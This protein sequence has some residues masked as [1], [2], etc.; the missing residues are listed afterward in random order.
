MLQNFLAELK[1]RKVLRVAGAYAVVAWGALQIADKL[2]PALL[3]PQW[4]ITFVAMLLLIGLP[5]TAII[6]WAFEMTPEGLR[7]TS[8]EIGPDETPARGTWIEAALLLSIVAVAGITVVQMLHRAEPATAPGDAVET[9][10]PADSNS[11][12][13][14]PFTSFSDD[15]DSNYFADGLTEELI[16]DLAHIAGL[17]VSGRTSSFYFKNRNEDLRDIGRK[18]GVAQVLEGS[19]RR[20]GEKLR[21]TVQ[22]ISTADG[23][24]L[25]SQTYDRELNDIFEIQDDVAEHVASVLEMTLGP[26]RPNAPGDAED[27]RQYLIASALLHER[28]LEPLTQARDLFARLKDREPDNVDALAGYTQATMLLAGAFMTLDFEPAARDAI[29]TIE[30]ALTIDPDSVTA[31]VA[32]GAAYT[33][34]LHRT[35]ESRYR[36]LAQRSLARAVELAPDDPEAL[37]SY[38]SLLNEIGQFD[39]AYAAL[40]RAVARDPMSRLAQAQLITALEGLGRLA[41]ARERLLILA[42]MY[43]DYVFAQSELGELLL[44]QGQIDAALPYLRKAHASKTSPRAS[45]ALAH[46]YVNLGLD[47][48][49]RQ[50][51]AELSYSPRSQ[52]FGEVILLNVRGDDAATFRLAQSQLELT[53]DPIW[54][55]LLINA[56]LTLG[57]LATARRELAHTDPLLLTSLDATH[58]QPESALYAG[59]LLKREGHIEDA[60]RLLDSL[61]AAQAPPPHGYDPVARKL[62]RAKALALLGRADSAIDELRAAQLQGNRMLWD[63]DNFQRLDHATAFATLRDDPR[64]RA[65]IAEMESANHAMRER[66]LQS[67]RTQE[68]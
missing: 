34:L 53:N 5:I 22:L 10:A 29:A 54:R 45:F 20:S 33:V 6:T 40:H 32:A 24:H 27:Y 44:A 46:A 39:E 65:I 25:W 48:A 21:I 66:V 18:L 13:V 1:R 8:S 35:D 58:A 37:A 4:T 56:A 36:D 67:E 17:K 50:T 23:F 14:L 31:N 38:G 2:F 47:D 30:R 57:D 42:Q 41:E 62:V 49:L 16:N 11:I 3:L 51:L 19:V 61:L 64:F 68:D 28:A 7:R 43:P 15:T 60:T 26:R 59:E 9:T 63:F 52:P 12:A 55:A